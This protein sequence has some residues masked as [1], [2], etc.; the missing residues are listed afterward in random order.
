[1]DAAT[2]AGS[3]VLQ[4]IG[5]IL[6]SGWTFLQSVTV[7]GFSFS[8]ATLFVG[9]FLASLGLRF[10]GMILGVSIHDSDGQHLGE[11][12]NAITRHYWSK[13]WERSGS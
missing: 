8:F 11:A 2:T 9:L 6:S 5:W 4:A 13:K 12:K 7:P 3:D 10:L 1:M